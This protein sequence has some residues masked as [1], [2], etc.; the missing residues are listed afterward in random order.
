MNGWGCDG[1]A[2]IAA[3]RAGAIDPFG[4]TADELQELLDAS[5]REWV[6]RLA[7]LSDDEVAAV[8]EGRMAL[9]E[10]PRPAESEAAAWVRREDE[11]TGR[12]RALQAQRSRLEAEERELLAARFRRV[13]EEGG[14][15]V[16]GLREA[17]S[18]L[19]AEL[20]QSD[21][22]VE[23]RMAD[24]WTIVTQ[25][26]ATHEAHKTGRIS[27]GHL[28][29][30]EQAT[31]ALRTDIGADPAEAAKV[32][33][34]LVAIAE[35]TTPGRLRARAKLVVNRV[36]TDPLQQR[37]DAAHE[38]RAVWMVDAGDGMVDLGARLPAVVGA[39]I[40]DRLTQAAK[41]KPK[42]DPRTFDQ[43]RAD[44]FGELLLAGVTPD[45]VHG[46]SPI[47]ATVTITIPA[48]ELLRDP[49]EPE[50]PALRF[51]ALLDGKILVDAATVRALA[52]ETIVWERLFL[53]PVTGLPVTVDTYTPNRAMR[54]WLKARDGRCRWPGCTNPVQRADLDH[55]HAWADGGPTSIENLAHLCRR[56]HVMKHATKWTVR[57]L[58]GGVLEWTSPLGT[59][60]RDEPEPQ[61]PV[62]VETT[63]LWGMVTT[64]AAPPGGPAPPF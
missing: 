42:D 3:I 47:K 44:A 29:V 34:E 21:R 38:Q 41:G 37:H 9:P 32:E 35:T 51:P 18:I 63:D 49:D 13:Q 25:L 8:A 1:E 6:A 10:L 45:D 22:G 62:F 19:A 53:H 27:G 59:V 33:R 28:R 57:Q 58:P 54:R 5:D 60:F 43:F 50:E 55:T 24:A 64:G 61:G 15:A 17:A 7:A 39:G 36:L 30:I 40:F 31:H 4:R 12:V 48:T 56:H 2:Y 23:R 46:V 52:A 11:F 26:P 14:P 20:R 16:A